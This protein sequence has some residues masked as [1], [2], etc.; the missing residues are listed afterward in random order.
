MR[1]RSISRLERRLEPV[2]PL[3][4]LAPDMTH[5]EVV[6]GAMKEELSAFQDDALKRRNY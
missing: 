3:A 4:L 1:R 6:A 5:R 2:T